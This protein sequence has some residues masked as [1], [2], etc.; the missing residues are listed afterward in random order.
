[1]LKVDRPK[2]LKENALESLRDA[3]TAD[4]LKPG[5]RLVE[6]ALCESMGS[7]GRWYVNV[8]AIWRVS[9]WW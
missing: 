5:E 8:S 3:I 6:R 7:A 4:L 2:T 1:M 9:G